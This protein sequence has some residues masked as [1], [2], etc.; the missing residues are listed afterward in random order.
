MIYFL[1][2]SFV[3]NTAPFNRALAYWNSIDKMQIPLKVI[4]LMPDNKKSRVLESYRHIDVEY[5]WDKYYFSNR[6]LKYCSYYLYQF[7]FVRRLKKGDKVYIYGLEKISSRILKKNGVELYIESTECPEVYSNLHPIHNPKVPDFINVCKRVNGLFVISSNLKE[8]YIKKGIDARKIHIINMIVDQERFQGLQ[9]SSIVENYIA[10][11]GTASNNK[12]GVN[13]LIQA[14]AIVLKTYPNIKLYIIGDT[15]SDN[16]A[17][18][19]LK[20]IQKLGLEHNIIFTGR[21]SSEKMPQILLDAKILALARPDN[22]QAKYGFPTKLGEYL[23]TG[24]PV[25]VT[26]VGDIPRFL[27]DGVSALISPPDDD[28]SFAS[29]IIWAL[30]NPIESQ[31]IG[32]KGKAIAEHSFNAF[33]ETEKLMNIMLKKSNKV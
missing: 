23:M 29:K 12:D 33:N 13:R 5:Y 24:N 14:F 19:N 1:Y 6:F 26:A 11:C 22:L 3:P 21:I 17:V 31:S 8:Y 30:N 16:D 2:F 10:Y 4:F 7:L 28:E 9:K 15:P 18:G 25:V 27:Q 32:M 20:L